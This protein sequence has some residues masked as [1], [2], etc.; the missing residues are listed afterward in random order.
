[1]T[2]P[3]SHLSSVCSHEDAGCDLPPAF[4]LWSS[5]HKGL[6]A[7]WHVFLLGFFGANGS[8]NYSLH[9]STESHP[10]RR[11]TRHRLTAVGAP[12][13]QMRRTRQGKEPTQQRRPRLMSSYFCFFE[14]NTDITILISHEISY[15]Q[16]WQA[17]ISCCTSLYIRGS[18]FRRFSFCDNRT[19]QLLFQG[20]NLRIQ[21]SLISQKLWEQ[22]KNG[23]PTPPHCE[24]AENSALENLPPMLRHVAGP[25]NHQW[26]LPSKRDSAFDTSTVAGPCHGGGET[27]R[28]PI[29]LWKT[30]WF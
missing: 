15:V 27:F 14:F 18:R 2:A 16:S 22:Q 28:F 26:R 4:A 6:G 11:T 20:K 29:D 8:L 9:L 21:T 24:S 10:Y 25:L 30:L 1:M 13:S 23:P 3:V 19:F 17:E 12:N 5:A 7:H